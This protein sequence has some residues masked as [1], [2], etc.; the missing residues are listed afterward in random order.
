M[1]PG[2]QNIH[3]SSNI[4]RVII[5]YYME[6]AVNNLVWQSMLYVKDCAHITRE[7]KKPNQLK[8]YSDIICTFFSPLMKNWPHLSNREFTPTFQPMANTARTQWLPGTQ[9][10]SRVLSHLSRLEKAL[11]HLFPLHWQAQGAAMLPGRC[12]RWWFYFAGCRLSRTPVA[13]RKLLL[14]KVKVL[15]VVLSPALHSVWGSTSQVPLPSEWGR[16]EELGAASPS[17]ALGA[18]LLFSVRKNLQISTP[19]MISTMTSWHLCTSSRICRWMWFARHWDPAMWHISGA[20]PFPWPCPHLS[21]PTPAAGQE[22]P[23]APAPLT[24]VH[25]ERKLERLQIKTF[26]PLHIKFNYFF[27]ADPH[28]ALR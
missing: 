7:G 2:K 27:S 20:V 19:S 10:W 5:K 28:L 3:L 24:C 9:R 14:K 4:D 6:V 16:R 11:C 13:I 17:P 26:P 8:E 23:Q 25:L 12:A 21:L 15:P 1:S 22:G 18:T